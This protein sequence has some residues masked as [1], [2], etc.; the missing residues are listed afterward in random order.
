ML[1][2]L[3]QSLT[4][5]GTSH[6]NQRPN[7]L[8]D[9]EVEKELDRIYDWEDMFHDEGALDYINEV[10]DETDVNKID[11]VLIAAHIYVTRPIATTLPAREPLIN[12]FHKKYPGYSNI[13]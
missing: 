12:R 6:D 9:L 7:I 10:L 11:P 1:R 5:A 3:K 13:K 2:L 4:P 8:S